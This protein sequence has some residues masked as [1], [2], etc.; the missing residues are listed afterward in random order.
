MNLLIT[1]LKYLGERWIFV[2]G[3]RRSCNGYSRR[4]EIRPPGLRQLYIDLGMGLLS[5]W[6]KG[7]IARSRSEVVSEPDVVVRGAKLRGGKVGWGYG[8]GGY[9]YE[10]NNGQ[11]HGGRRDGEPSPYSPGKQWKAESRQLGIG[12]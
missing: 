5:P 9:A 8:E 11:R 4:C 2:L 6:L 10:P 3:G 12:K 1:F 7:R